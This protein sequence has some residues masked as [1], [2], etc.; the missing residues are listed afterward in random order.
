MNLF[1]RQSKRINLAFKVLVVL[2]CIVAL[3]LSGC[4]ELPSD[5]GVIWGE[6]KDVTEDLY[7]RLKSG[8]FEIRKDPLVCKLISNS[9]PKLRLPFKRKAGAYK[10]AR[11]SWER[12]SFSVKSDDHALIVIYLDEEAVLNHIQIAPVKGFQLVRQ[13][14]LLIRHPIR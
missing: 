3:G 10:M 9:S 5:T 1:F 12:G 6:S 14:R 8:I 13:F 2:L 11:I 7:H 4:Q